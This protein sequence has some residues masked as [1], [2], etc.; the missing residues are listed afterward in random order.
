M[1]RD[2]LIARMQARIEAL[3]AALRDV[4]V[5]NADQADV[6]DTRTR[7]QQLREDTDRLRDA[8]EPEWW[9]VTKQ[10][11]EMYIERI[12]AAIDRLTND[13]G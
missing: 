9:D 4:N 7:V 3:E 11:V 8:S 13:R 2:R 5:R 10:R 12:D 1:R 6:E